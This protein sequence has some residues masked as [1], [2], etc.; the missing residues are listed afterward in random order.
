MSKK[1]FLSFAAAFIMV[2]AGGLYF[3]PAD[4]QKGAPADKPVKVGQCYDCH[5]DIK[6]FH[7][8]GKHAKVNCSTC[9][10]GLNNHLKDVSSK[11]VTKMDLATCGKCHKEEYESLVSVDID[12]RAKVEKATFKSR[13]PLFDKLLMPHG[14]T[15][16]HAEP[17]S[18]VFMLMD[19]LI[20]DR[21][22]GGRFQLKDWK[23][24]GDAKGAEK[25]LWST[26]IDKDPASSDQ[27]A[28]L[29]Q[30]ATAANPVCFQCKTQD[31]ILDWKYM[32]DK[33]PRAKWDR[34]SKVVE[35]A[36]KMS[37]PMNCFTCHDP[38]STQPRVVRDALI[39]AV[40]DRGEGTYPY[41][42][43]K[44]KKITM[45]KVTFRDGFRAIGVLNKPD[46]VLLCA[47]CHVEYTCNPGINTETGKPVGMD[48]QVT[49]FFSW[50][51]V[52]DYNKKM[53]DQ[54]QIKNQLRRIG[55]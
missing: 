6:E 22:Y 39:Q 21:A 38:H 45:K 51:N 44:S 16:E 41:D 35:F 24:I 33:D 9:H 10:E 26:L 54:S 29:P 49:N 37:H 27:K 25:N 48:N 13:S 12:S 31:M 43:E 7:S 17:R 1:L 47:Q 2:I 40:V 4:A 3:S 42:K 28:F 32:G 15:K 34:T 55:K 11:P 30:T 52:F 18:H 53:A 20:V 50:V 8:S 36:R 5:S 19:H 46:S 14:F 23:E